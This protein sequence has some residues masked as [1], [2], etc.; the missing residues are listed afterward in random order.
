[1]K[2]GSLRRLRLAPSGAR[3]LGKGFFWGARHRGPGAVMAATNPVDQLIQFCLNPPS[4]DDGTERD[5]MR[6]FI[7]LA[8]VLFYL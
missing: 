5:A 7:A 1:M 4:P 6:E 2:K 3:P 8:R